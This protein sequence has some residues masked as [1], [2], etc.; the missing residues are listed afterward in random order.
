MDNFIH[1]ES[2]LFSLFLHENYLSFLGRSESS[3]EA[4]ADYFSV[5]DLLQATSATSASQGLKMAHFH[6]SGSGQ[7]HQAVQ[8]QRNNMPISREG[9]ALV[10]MYGTAYSNTGDTPRGKEVARFKKSRLNLTT[11][12]QRENARLMHSLLRLRIEKATLANNIDSTLLPL[13][14]AISVR[15][16]A[17]QLLPLLQRIEAKTNSST[18]SSDSFMKLMCWYSVDSKSAAASSASGGRDQMID[19]N[20]KEALED[21]ENDG[22]A[23]EKARSDSLEANFSRELYDKLNVELASAS[24]ELK[25]ARARAHASMGDEEDPIQND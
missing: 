3:L 12:R 6:Y 1:T 18:S 7:G 20:F 21:L 8:Q 10:A 19:S 23:Q 4:A 25:N 2:D 11:H 5:S 17:T 14:A 16:A 13:S 22:D 24:R 15:E 9:A